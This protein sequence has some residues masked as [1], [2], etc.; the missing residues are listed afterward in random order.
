MVT[1]AFDATTIINYKM[2]YAAGKLARQVGLEAFT[3][4]GHFKQP[5]T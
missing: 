4:E 2:L 3:Y 1:M 5:V